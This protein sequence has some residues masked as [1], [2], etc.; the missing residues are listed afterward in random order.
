MFQQCVRCRFKWANRRY[1]IWCYGM[2]NYQSDGWIE[3][4][5]RYGKVPMSWELLKD[6]AMSEMTN[7]WVI[8][9]YVTLVHIF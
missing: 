8:K 9:L 4:I 6:P 5:T 3:E 2:W 1:I 7:E